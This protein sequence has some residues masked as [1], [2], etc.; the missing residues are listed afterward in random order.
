MDLADGTQR[1]LIV[2]HHLVID[3]VSWRI[4][5]E[6]VASVYGQTAR[7]RPMPWRQRANPF[8]LGAR[9]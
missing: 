2:V 3:G 1:L 8:V 5:L 9:A 6:D 4:L 7:A